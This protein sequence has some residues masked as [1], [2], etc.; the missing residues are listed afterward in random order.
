V[1]AVWDTIAQQLL[2]AATSTDV[3]VGREF[4]APG[5]NFARDCSLIAVV[6]LR[7]EVVPL[8]RE[9]A[10]AC[11]AVTQMA[12]EVV[13][14]DDCVPTQADN[15]QPPSPA[16][17]SAWSLA[18]LAKCAKIHAAVMTAASD[19]QIAGGCHQ[20]S[21]GRGDMR[22]PLGSQASMIVPITVTLVDL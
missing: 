11:A 1:V 3:T 6:L 14:V 9:F 12:F 13:F 8:Q 4:V 22:G 17:V 5:P 16:A 2:D 19:G 10:G 21:V 7:P 15:G 18:Y 20:I